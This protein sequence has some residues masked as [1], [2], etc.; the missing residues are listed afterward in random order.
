MFIKTLG[1]GIIYSPIFSI[2]SSNLGM[3][4]CPSRLSICFFL[5]NDI[6]SRIIYQYFITILAAENL[7]ASRGTLGKGEEKGNF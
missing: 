6:F 2:N 7:K 3:F 5:Y 4:L 1:T